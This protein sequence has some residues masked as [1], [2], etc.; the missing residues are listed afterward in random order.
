MIS[1]EKVEQRNSK[2]LQ[3]RFGVSI[4]FDAL[5]NNVLNQELDVLV[6][7]FEDNYPDCFVWYP[8]LHMTLI[9]CKSVRLPFIVNP[10][11]ESYKQMEKELM[12]HP[13]FKLEY[14]GSNIGSDGVLRCYFSNV[15][16]KNLSA[17]KQFYACNKMNYSI[18]DKPWIALG[19]I[20]TEEFGNIRM[21][22]ERIEDILEDIYISNID[23]Q[24]MDVI[25]YEDI[26]LRKCQYLGSIKLGT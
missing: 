9:R 14:A 17:V 24:I 10:N 3:E 23:I 1:L 7:Q 4:I 16:W 8:R 6:R 5:Q 22:M 18:I 19:N 21:N 13:K 2:I 20:R 15:S 25:Y 11:D 26:L 12:V